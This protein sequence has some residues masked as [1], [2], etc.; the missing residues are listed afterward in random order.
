MMHQTNLTIAKVRK[1]PRTCSVAVAKLKLLHVQVAA[2]SRNQ[3]CYTSGSNK[4]QERGISPFQLWLLITICCTL[5]KLVSG[6]AKVTQIHCVVFDEAHKRVDVGSTP[7]AP[8][9]AQFPQVNQRKRFVPG[10]PARKR[11]NYGGKRNAGKVENVCSGRNGVEGDAKK[12]RGGRACV[13]D[14]GRKV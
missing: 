1:T 7:I 10:M 13:A 6:A 14:D 9:R 11:R 2:E 5:W 3:L 4:H 8:R 12:V